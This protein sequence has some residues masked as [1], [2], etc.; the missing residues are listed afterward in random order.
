MAALGVRC[1]VQA[2]YSRGAPLQ[3]RCTGFS[4]RWRLLQSTGSRVRG[5]RSCSLWVPGHGLSR[6]GTGAYL[7]HGTWNRRPGVTPMTP[8]LAGRSLTTRPSGKSKVLL[9]IGHIFESNIAF[10][11]G[12][13]PF[14]LEH[15]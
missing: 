4:L 2:F 9:F 1:C 14:M 3:L 8:A 13:T 15:A 6:C 7:P 11:F 5:F 12:N 10:S